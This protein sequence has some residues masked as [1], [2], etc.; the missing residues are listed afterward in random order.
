MGVE[1]RTIS[2]GGRL[3]PE[4]TVVNIKKNI[5]S[6]I[7]P[8]IIIGL[9][10]ALGYVVK[11]EHGLKFSASGLLLCAILCVV[12]AA[13]IALLFCLW[14]RRNNKLLLAVSK[15]DYLPNRV[16]KKSWLYFLAMVVVLLILWLPALLAFY[17]GIYAYDASWQYDMYRGGFV[18]EHHPVVHTYLVGW[19]LDTV[20]TRTGMFNKAVLAYTIV[21]EFI[22]ALGCGFVFYELHRRREP[23]WMHVLALLMFCA[24]PPFVIFVFSSTKD[25]LF[26][27]AVADF[28]FLS[29]GMAEDAKAFWGRRTN[30]VLWIVFALEIVALRNNSVYAVLLTLP[31]VIVSMAKSQ[32]KGTRFKAFRSL[33]IATV[34]FLI[35]KYPITNAVTVEGVSKA[36]MLSVPCQQIM[37]VYTYHGDEI[38]R[39]DKALVEQLFDESKY[40][41]YYNPCMADA[42]KGSL[43]KA[44][45]N[46]EFGEFKSLWL[47]LF[48][49][50]PG[51]YVD[52]FLENTY[53]FWYPWPKYVLHS[54]G[55][56]GY[57]P[58][59]VMQ[60][61]EQNSKLPGL[62]EFYKQ[63][64]KSDVVM[65]NNWISWLF[66]PATFLYIAI[67]VGFYLLK[68]KKKSVAIPFV[69]LGLLWLTFL[70]GPV[71]MVRYALYL[72]A[73]VP[74]WP[75]YIRS[76]AVK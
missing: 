55:G 1:D 74:V 69:Y 70:L 21:Q 18:S 28:V 10:C 25:S 7:V 61:G 3:M 29:L 53:G 68:T 73:L 63:F 60:P 67:V 8:G 36:E 38:S 47:K 56:E 75:A 6:S 54:L 44:A 49:E 32:G 71:A 52:S 51:E 50:Y 9:F 12:A 19:I 2:Y 62:L 46:E 76:K 17:P 14:D 66:A 16:I 48:K 15:N 35:Y 64:E 26:A 65:G 31:F 40:H 41:Y 72:Y 23:T 57:T 59:L 39:E 20:Y 5:L 42:T 27:I 22:M 13:V 34:I 43:T 45:T 58:I 37:R 11:Y 24:Y 30:R 33:I 4:K